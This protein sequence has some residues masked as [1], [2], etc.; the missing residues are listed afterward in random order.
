METRIVLNPRLV[1]ERLEK[2]FNDHDAEAWTE[3]LSPFYLS[4]QPTHPDR[5]FRGRERAGEEWRQV[6][7]RVPNFKAEVV[8]CL[9][10]QES[11]WVE[12]H[13]SGTRSDKKRLDLWGVSIHGVK[14]NQI[15]WSRLYLDPVQE[16]GQGIVSLT[17]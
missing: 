13:L 5:S 10:D 14:D 9:T 8:R 3:C 11:A 15:T 17:G 1:I 12:W 4:E 2:A 7:A 16:P 6:F